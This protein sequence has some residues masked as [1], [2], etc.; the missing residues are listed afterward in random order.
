MK[1]FTLVL[2]EM[3]RVEREKRKKL[4]KKLKQSKEK[5]SIGVQSDL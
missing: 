5:S 4:E 1:K 2:E 3:L